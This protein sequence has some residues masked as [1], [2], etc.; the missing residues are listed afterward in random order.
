[1]LVEEELEE[2][3]VSIVSD[4][5]DSP[6]TAEATTESVNDEEYA[7]SEEELYELMQEVEDELQ[8]EEA[9]YAEEFLNTAEYYEQLHQ[10]EL[11]WQI[12]EF[13]EWEAINQHNETVPCPICN[14]E[15]ILE[16]QDWFV[17]PNNM[18]GTCPFKVS[19]PDINFSLADLKNSLALA[20][21]THAAHCFSPIRFVVDKRDESELTTL[22]A[23]C[24]DCNTNNQVV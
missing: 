6:S 11:E 22:V 19:K 7:I 8:R 10:Q 9:M 16:E 4:N 15:A 5:P 1:M 3:G 2:S 12:A 17:C 20:L 23:L 21:E 13:E 24:T 14:D 18:Q